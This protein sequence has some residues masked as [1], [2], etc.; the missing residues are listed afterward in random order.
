M[1][2]LCGIVVALLVTSSALAEPVPTPQFGYGI[3]GR[4]CAHWLSDP[5]TTSEG[6]IWLA[7]YWSGLNAM[8]PPH[9]HVGSTTD[10]D[11]MWAEVKTVCD[12]NPTMLLTNAADAVYA[13][14][15]REGK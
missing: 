4:S 14:F 8:N 9:P 13:R 12:A 1:R 7:G 6:R 11:A 2:G 10:G 15:E 3:G 5:A